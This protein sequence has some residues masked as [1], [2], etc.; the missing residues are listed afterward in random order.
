MTNPAVPTEQEPI[1]AYELLSTPT[2]DLT[3]AQVE[4][5]VEDLRSK[6]A[7]YLASGK[8]DR[9]KA[10]AKAKADPLSKEAKALQKAENTRQLMASLNLG[11]FSSDAN[12]ASPAS[13]KPSK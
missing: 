3:D 9:P 6:R 11:L 4:Q 8:Q 7:F 1:G 5:I 10:A 12:P 13:S 2:L